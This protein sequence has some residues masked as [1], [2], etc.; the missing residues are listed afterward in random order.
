V[1]EVK[2]PK[3]I[4]NVDARLTKLEEAIKRPSKD[5]WDRVNAASG[6]IGGVLVAGIGFYAT[7]VYDKRS[8]E[9]ED[10]DRGRNVVAM[11]LQTVEKFFPHLASPNETEKQA[12]IEAISSLANPE[13]AAKMA[14][15]FGGSG[16]RAALTN[17]VASAKTE[18]GSGVAIALSDLYKAFSQSVG[19]LKVNIELDNGALKEVRATC[20]VITEDGYALTT[21]H[22][23]A[24]AAPDSKWRITVSLGSPFIPERAAHLI[25]VDKEL[26]LALVKIDEKTFTPVKYAVEPLD[27][28]AAVTVLGFPTYLG[29]ATATAGRVI[30]SSTSLGRMLLDIP[31]GVLG[32]G[33]D[34]SPIFNSKGEVIGL[35]ESATSERTVGLPIKFARPLISMAGVP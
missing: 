8:K 18:K 34:G 1:G 20:V 11:E 4:G 30:V 21:G 5:V 17:I 22:I 7:E 23:F 14:R 3:Q 24:T 19:L 6:I 13:L 12:A 10:R 32:A 33:G 25:K 9:A 27:V 16:A 29:T 2:R 31:S 28:G 26:D 35:V 15:V